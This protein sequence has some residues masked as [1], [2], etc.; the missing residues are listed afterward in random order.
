MSSVSHT[1]FCSLP[2]M[3]GMVLSGA[4]EQ[5]CLFQGEGWE[6]VEEKEQFPSGSTGQFTEHLVASS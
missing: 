6:P 4:C 3:T 5:P 1:S 2:V